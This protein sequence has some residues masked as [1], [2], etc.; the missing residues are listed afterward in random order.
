MDLFSDLIQ[1]VQDDMNLN[2]QSPLYPLARVK[3]A[4]NR[5]YIKCGGLFLWPGT[6]D[7]KKT[8]TQANIE[9]YDY[10]VNWRDDSIWR[11]EV[12]DKQYGETPDGSPMKFE[13]YLTW[14]R[15]TNN[16]NSTDKKWANQKRRYFIYPVPTS[17]GSYNISVWGQKVVDALSDNSDYTI[18]SY[19]MPECNDAVVLE[20]EAILKSQGHEEKAGEFR[21]TEA[22]QILVGAWNKIRQSQDKYEKGQPFLDVPDFF[23]AK[24]TKDNTIGNFN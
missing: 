23:R 8:S 20:A 1:G 6:E 10:P 12:D 18:F 5:S 17:A 19:S 7:A 3:R 9:Y 16:A 21:S 11:L 14:R 2:D 13:D 22:K 15:D 24:S 4:I